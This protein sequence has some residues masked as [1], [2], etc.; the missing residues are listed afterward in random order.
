MEELELE[1]LAAQERKMIRDKVAAG[2]PPPKSSPPDT[3]PNTTKHPRYRNFKK[4]PERG[5]YGVINPDPSPDAPPKHLVQEWTG[6]RTRPK[7]RQ[8]LKRYNSVY[9]DYD[10]ISAAAD[11]ARMRARLSIHPSI[12]P[13]PTTHL[14]TSS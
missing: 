14:A 2:R 8:P 9:E 11:T 13:P 4:G 1:I 7:S 6:T 12:H 3:Q 10:R 5:T